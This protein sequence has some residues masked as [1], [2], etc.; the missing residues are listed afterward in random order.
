MATAEELTV[1]SLGSCR[2]DSPIR[3]MIESR[4]TSAHY[5]DVDDRVYFYDTKQLAEGSGL[6]SSPVADSAPASTM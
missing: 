6:A 1:T 2:I 4:S 5:V 3:G